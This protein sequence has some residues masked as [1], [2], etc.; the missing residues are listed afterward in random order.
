MFNIP[1]IIEAVGYL[2]IFL[3]AF[4]ESGILLGFFLPGDTM[5]FTAG[6]LAYK[7]LFNYWLLIAI[8]FSAAVLGDTVG[9][10]L[11]RK[12]GPAIFKKNDSILFHQDH[13]ER[14]RHFYERH[15][16]KTIILARFMPI[17]RTL[18]PILAGVGKMNYPRFV[19]YNI[20]G[21]ALWTFGLITIGFYLGSVIPNIEYFVLPIVLFILFISVV[22]TLVTILKNKNYRERVVNQI[23]N[24]FR[25][26]KKP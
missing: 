25:A 8:T 16:C 18:A 1:L 20:A 23:Q 15:G 4:A 19:I 2:G 7:G 9:Y 6:F 14:A 24:I 11:G 10:T 21:G 17:I 3:I 26:R 12:I 5:L 22:P 13:L